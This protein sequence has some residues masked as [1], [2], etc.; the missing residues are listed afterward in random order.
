MADKDEKYI[1]LK[2]EFAKSIL[3]Q[4]ETLYI[5]DG[6]MLLRSDIDAMKAAINPNY[7]NS[8]H[9]DWMKI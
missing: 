1:P 2:M 6:S 7:F 3:K 4:L 9:K 8:V 5:I